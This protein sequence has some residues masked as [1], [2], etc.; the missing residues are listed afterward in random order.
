MLNWNYTAISSIYNVDMDTFVICM[1]M[2]VIMCCMHL[3]LCLRLSDMKALCME[4]IGFASSRIYDVVCIFN[5]RFVNIGIYLYLN[6]TIL[7]YILDSHMAPYGACEV[8]Q[9]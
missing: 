2:W 7:I 5:G 9:S 8:V 4:W 6:I 1:W 3:F